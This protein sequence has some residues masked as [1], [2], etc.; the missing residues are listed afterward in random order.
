MQEAI[1]VLLRQL[2]LVYGTYL[3]STGKLDPDLLQPWIGFSLAAVSV[4]WMI[5]D[6]FI[7]PKVKLW[8]VLLGDDDKPVVIETNTK[9]VSVKDAKKMV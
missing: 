1:I 3:V 5:W 2:L 6:R 7:Y 4:G 9:D 8:I